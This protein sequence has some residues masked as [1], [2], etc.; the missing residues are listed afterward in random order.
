MTAVRYIA[1]A[2]AIGAAFTVCALAIRRWVN[3][4]GITVTCPDCH[5]TQVLKDGISA[6]EFRQYHR[7]VHTAEANRRQRTNASRWN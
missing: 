3:E 6:D 5:T 7:T 4:K 1:G 2:G